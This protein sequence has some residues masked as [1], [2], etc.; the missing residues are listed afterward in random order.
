MRSKI[1]VTSNVSRDFLQN[2]DYFST[3]PKVIW[4]YV[5]NSLDNSKEKLPITVAVEIN[6]EDDIVIVADNGTGMSRKDLERF[7]TMHGENIQRA[8]G[9]R[10]RGR[11][12]TGKSA[13]FGIAKKLTIETKQNHLLNIVSLHKDDIKKAIDGKP[14][15]VNEIKTDEYTGEEDGTIIKIQEIF[16]KRLDIESSISFIEKNLARYHVKAIVMING[17]TCKF[18]EPP[19]ANIYRVTAPIS[20]Q[21]YIGNPELIIKLAPLS[22]SQDERGIDILSEGIWHETTLGEIEGKEFSERFFGEVDIPL[23]EKVDDDIA[24]FDN[25]R[26]NLLNR[27]N[28]RVVILIGWISQEL[29]K[30]RQIIVQEEKE[31]K[32]TEQ[33]KKLEQEASKMANVLNEDFKSLMID[34]DVSRKI[35]GRGSS[36][37][38]DKDTE[39]GD[40]FPGDGDDNSNWRESGQPHANGQKGTNP[41]GEG[42]FPR[43]GPDLIPGDDQGSRKQFEDKGPKRRS[44]SF[45]IEFANLTEDFPRSKYERDSHRI[46]INLDHPQV[47]LAF[48]DGGNTLDSRSFL[49]MIYEVAAVEYAQTIPFTRLA[50]GELVDASEALFAVGDTIDRIT[51]KFSAIFSG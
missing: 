12:G 23:L 8:R 7:F 11:F 24:P 48:K 26:N 30:V 39:S 14:F 35:S 45:S 22:L 3:L 34:I 41:P 50:L 5:S 40:I 27:S 20:I 29:E 37:I 47:A 42:E 36:K 32:K 15:F 6:K 31:K 9:K 1:T 33:S 38:E 43:P 28:P 51:R 44:G 21:Q 13:A 4:E 10:V 19:V 46:L 49:S 17:H 2:A 25:T 18:K 16:E